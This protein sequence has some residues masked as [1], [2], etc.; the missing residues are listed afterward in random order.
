MKRSRILRWSYL[1]VKYISLFDEGIPPLFRIKSK[2]FGLYFGS[3]GPLVVGRYANIAQA[4]HNNDGFVR[5][6]HHVEIREMA[7]VDYSGG[8]EIGNHVTISAGAKIY[9]HNHH[10]WHRDQLWTEQPILFSPLSIGDDAWIGSGAIILPG[11]GRIGQG[12]IVGAGAI[13]TREVM[14]Y[15][16]VVG[17]PARIVGERS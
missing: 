8:L 4:H 15:T 9:T 7:I 14:D 2:I 13:V 11:V 16:V 12:A 10:V 17:N 5:I 3:N 1:V 6:G